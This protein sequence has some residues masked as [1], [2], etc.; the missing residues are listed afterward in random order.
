MT[1][2]V[3]QQAVPAKIAT[4]VISC[5]FTRDFQKGQTPLEHIGP[6][7]IVKGTAGPVM[8]RSQ[9]SAFGVNVCLRR[10][11]WILRA[12]GAWPARSRRVPL[13]QNRTFRANPRRHLPIICW[14]T[15]Q[16]VEIIK[17]FQIK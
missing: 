11:A 8:I 13:Y 14:T 1:V 17:K 2:T 12:P 6:P 16:W 10:S 4:R 15:P 7:S 5:I 3:A 9:L